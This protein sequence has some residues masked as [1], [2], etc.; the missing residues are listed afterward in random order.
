[1][2]TNPVGVCFPFPFSPYLPFLFSPQM[3][4]K[5]RPSFPDIVRNLEEI[6]AR[7]KVEEMQH[8]CVPL[9]GDNDK[10]SIPKGK[11]AAQNLWGRDHFSF[12][13]TVNRSH[14]LLFT[15]RCLQLPVKEGG[16]N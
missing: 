4:P 2:E 15:W 12:S 9:S 13:F 10:K 1:M 6:L 8:E 16:W 14:L 11:S 7:L 3:D 5:L